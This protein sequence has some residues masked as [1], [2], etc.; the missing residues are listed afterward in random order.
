MLNP[1]SSEYLDVGLAK[2]Y[3]VNITFV[4]TKRIHGRSA[5]AE[6]SDENEKLCAHATNKKLVI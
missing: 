2:F 1:F 4:V 5:K 3:D 6:P